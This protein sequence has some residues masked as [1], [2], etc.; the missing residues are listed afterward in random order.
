MPFAR[1]GAGIVGAFQVHQ[2]LRWEALVLDLI[3]CG[4]GKLDDPEVMRWALCRYEQAQLRGQQYCR[5]MEEAW[6]HDLTLRR[7]IDRDD[8]KVLE[9]AFRILPSRLFANLKPAIVERWSRWS[10]H[11]G[12]CATPVLIECPFDDIGPLLARHMAGSLPD[13]E[14][15][16]AVITSLTRLSKSDALAL[17][18]EATARVSRLQDKYATK[19]ILLQQLLRPTA[20]LNPAGLVTLAEACARAHGHDPAD[21]DRLLRAV[22]LA[23]LG[24]DA[25]M[26]KARELIDGSNGHPFRSLQRLFAM[27]AP[28]E[29]CDHISAERDPWPAAK[30]LLE[31]HRGASAA[32]ETALSIV[33][34]MDSLGAAD[35]A[36]MAWFA[37]A[38]TMHPFE[39]DE[40]GADSLSAEEA[41]DALALDLS[42]NRLVP[43]LT[44]RL[45]TFPAADVARGVNERMPTVMDEWGSVHLANLAGELRLA[46]TIPTLINCLA[47]GVGDFLCEAAETALVR[48]GEPAAE[49]LSVRWDNLDASQRIYGRSVL[50]QTGGELALTFAIARFQGLFREDH[51]GWCSL[52]AAVPDRQLIDLIEPH[53]RRQQPMIDWCLYLMCVLMEYK[54][55]DL[56]Q[57]GERVRTH[58]RRVL[59]RQAA[60]ATGDFRDPDGR[61]A[62]TL[63]CE[64]C[65]DINHYD[66]KSVVTSN[67]TSE[68]G[69]FVAD[70]L[71]CV[72][73][74]EW[75]DFEFTMKAHMQLM[76]A[77]LR[78]LASARAGQAFNE[79]P[80]R[81]I[82]VN[83]R[84]E[85]RPAPE[86]LAEIKAAVARY[87][88]DVVNRLRL[89]RF[90]HVFGRLGRARECYARALLIEPDSLEAGLG[91]AQIMADTGEPRGAFD[92][93]CELLGRK[94]RWRFFRT[95]E[96]SPQRLLENFLSLFN[97]LHSQLGVHDRALLHA[98]AA[99]DTAK[100]GRNHPC[101]CGSGK[102][103]KKCCRDTGTLILSQNGRTEPAPAFAVGPQTRRL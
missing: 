61:I 28:L 70:D 88:Q 82:D 80:L 4:R 43:K 15:T 27:D 23:L 8:R 49:A 51:E 62:L 30:G 102:K 53:V 52:A 85:T 16:A 94:G 60:F 87:P 103:Y 39:R 47:E 95:D 38:A 57:I 45:S 65:G 50:E 100:V 93:L 96:L 97:K 9:A 92:K 2:F 58:G 101:P 90:Q 7:W 37:V 71:P 67:S 84:W 21:G 46:D 83:F 63:R 59:E 44:Q 77:L 86:V 76:G 29:E 6:F 14:K 41:L 89:A 11:L 69:Y 24:N 56:Q 75:V 74:G 64:K 31:K 36:D 17:L 22:G 73:C 25:L 99:Q 78:R 26:E 32:T 54:H 48:N 1:L 98:A 55:T 5:P 42:A 40:I 91:L 33:M 3:E 66:I 72:S 81:M 20:I 79:G 19:T 13:L 18:D 12:A 68:P 35:P 34:M 10:G